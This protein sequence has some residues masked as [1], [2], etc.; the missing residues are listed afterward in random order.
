M[1]GA[2]SIS[3]S[4]LFVPVVMLGLEAARI[5]NN[6]TDQKVN[7]SATVSLHCDAA[8]RPT[9]LVLWT[10]NNQTVVEGSGELSRGLFIKGKK[11]T[12]K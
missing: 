8:G 1:C 7:V 3:T 10:K 11:T 12:T 4:D 5:L 6:L 2:P 9:P